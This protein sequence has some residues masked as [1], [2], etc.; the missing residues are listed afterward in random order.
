MPDNTRSTIL[1]RAAAA[2]AK[3]NGQPTNWW[4]G[5]TVEAILDVIE[6]EDLREDVAE[7]L[8]MTPNTDIDAQIRKAER[9][10]FERGRFRAEQGK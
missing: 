7:W 1:Y 5:K 8:H 2:A 3:A 6:A 4:H 9:A 10:A